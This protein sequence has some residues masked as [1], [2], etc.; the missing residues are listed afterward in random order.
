MAQSKKFNRQVVIDKATQLYWQKGFHAT[1]MRCLQEAIDMRPGSIYS[2]FGSKEQL[3]QQTLV[4]YTEQLLAQL[5][6]CQ[7]TS[8]SPMQALKGFIQLQVIGP[9]N[10]H[11]N[12]MCM[13]AKTLA[14]L[15]DEQ[16]EL[17]ESVKKQLQQV[18]SAFVTVINKA[19][20]QG[21]VSKA[22]NAIDLANY[23]QIQ[24]AGLRTFAQ[25]ESDTNKLNSYINNIFIFGPFKQ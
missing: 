23:L 13:L 5:K 7:D 8:P 2:A 10:D 24:I 9:Q 21:E 12:N 25:L 22:L 4:N 15:N 1:S 20:E 16:A 19:Q 6:A 3:F 17:I 14:E 18:S 11:A